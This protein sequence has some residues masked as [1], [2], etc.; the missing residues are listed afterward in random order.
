MATISS[1]T[2]ESLAAVM[3]KRSG[4]ARRCS[5]TASCTSNTV[6][7]DGTSKVSVSENRTVSHTS[8]TRKVGLP[9]RW[10]AMGNVSGGA[11][12]GG[13]ASPIV[14][15]SGCGG[16]GSSTTTG[17]ACLCGL[18]LYG[19]RLR[20]RRCRWRRTLCRCCPLSYA[21]LLPPMS[22]VGVNLYFKVRSMPSFLGKPNG[23]VASRIL[24]LG[25]AGSAICSRAL[26]VWVVAVLHLQHAV[27]A[28]T[29]CATK[30]R[31]TICCIPMVSYG[32]VLSS[33]GCPCCCVV[34]HLFD[35][36]DKDVALQVG[37]GELASV[38]C[39]PKMVELSSVSGTGAVVVVVVVVDV[40]HVQI[41]V[42]ERPAG[43]TRFQG[44]SLVTVVYESFKLHVDEV[45]DVL[46]EDD[47]N[48]L[49]DDDLDEE[50]ARRCV[51]LVDEV[52][53]RS[54][55][56]TMAWKSAMPALVRL[57]ALRPATQA[58]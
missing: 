35:T 22:G 11:G 42:D 31:L 52:G 21:D 8:C 37:G 39:R 54:N 56:T 44:I 45:R 25:A 33:E 23:W 28:R 16:C 14:V 30:R 4:G 29:K 53:H 5:A 2:L 50:G 57:G 1:S 32:A 20:T 43:A 48:E 9:C 38:V 7:P 18:C 49:V 27:I 34:R 41:A 55:A 40:P 26:V 24:S 36:L 6:A 12:S 17:C 46:G 10:V 3:W 47:V 51:L 58:R 13:C 19:P 15:G